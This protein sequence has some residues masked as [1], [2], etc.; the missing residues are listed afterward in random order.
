M[1]FSFNVER[2]LEQG[3][4]LSKH[5]AGQDW[6]RQGMRLVTEKG[7]HGTARLQTH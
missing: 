7:R 5:L 6:M 1:T 3:A 2:K 4:G